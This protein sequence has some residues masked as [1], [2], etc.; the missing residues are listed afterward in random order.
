[1]SPKRLLDL[2]ASATLL[3]CALPVFGVVALLVKLDSPG[4]VFYRAKR[5]GKGGREFK[6]LKFRTMVAEADRQGPPV[7]YLRDP[8]ITRVGRFLRDTKLDELPQLWNVLKGD[9]SLVGPRA[10]DPR[11]RSAYEGRFRPLLD[12]PPGMTGLSWVRLKGFHEEKIDPGPDWEKH[13]TEVSL[14]R[15]LEADLEYLQT[16]SF[17]GDLWILAETLV[18]FLADRA[19]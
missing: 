16:R 12:V 9:M 19:K 6:M 11:Y 7:T 13:Y 18:G 15:K 14:P 2:S 8:R 1:M 3:A 17:F 5:L 10:E 4:P